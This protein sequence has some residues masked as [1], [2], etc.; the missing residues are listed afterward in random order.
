MT[1]DDTDKYEKTICLWLN[2]FLDFRLDWV[3]ENNTFYDL[4]GTTPKGNKCVVEIKVR[5]KYYKDKMLE[6][7]RI[8]NLQAEVDGNH[9]R[10]TRHKRAGYRKRSGKR[11]HGEEESGLYV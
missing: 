1:K 5:N 3:G 9:E 10:E 8:R 4:I 6:I 11:G 2:G 7:S